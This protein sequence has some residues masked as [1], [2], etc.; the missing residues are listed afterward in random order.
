MVSSKVLK[1]FN[2][3]S[4]FTFNF[5]EIKKMNKTNEEFDFVSHQAALYSP[6]CSIHT[7]SI[8]VR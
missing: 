4:N 7:Q 1:N 8:K 5:L 3:L 2:V 6:A